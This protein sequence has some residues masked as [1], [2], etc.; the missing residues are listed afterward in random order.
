MPPTSYRNF[1]AGRKADK[2]A[3]REEQFF[4]QYN[5]L[6]GYGNAADALSIL[7][8]LASAVMPIMRKRG[9]KVG[10]LS[11]FYPENPGLLGLNVN[12]GQQIMVRLRSPHNA[13]Q[14][15]RFEHCLDTLLH[16]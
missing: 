3:H 2:Y 10:T 16:E 14:F 9:W 4:G 12:R 15:L 11:E 8:R 7:R 13:L 1:D 5:H 6:N